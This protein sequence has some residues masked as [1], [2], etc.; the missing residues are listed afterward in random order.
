MYKGKYDKLDYGNYFFLPG[1]QDPTYDY[2]ARTYQGNILAQ[3]PALY[4]ALNKKPEDQFKPVSVDN[5][6]VYC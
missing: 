6:T 1:Q 5:P 3:L 2:Q 4:T